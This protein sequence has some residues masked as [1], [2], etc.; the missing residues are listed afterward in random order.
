MYE[1]LDSKAKD[2]A[3][4][5]FKD[6]LW[7]QADL[8][9]QDSA[10][11]QFDS[12][13]I[14]WDATKTD[15]QDIEDS[16]SYYMLTESF[17]DSIPTIKLTRFDS[18]GFRVTIP[19]VVDLQDS[20]NVV[21]SE[22]PVIA[23]IEE[24]QAGE[25]NTKIMTP[26][27]VAEQIVLNA[28]PYYG[29]NEDIYTDYNISA[30]TLKSNISDAKNY[31][32]NY[33][34]NIV[35][36]S[37]DHTFADNSDSALVTER[38]IKAFV[39]N[40]ISGG[41]I[42]LGGW[43]ANTNTPT[44]SDATGSNGDMYSITVSGTQDLGSGSIVWTAGG[45]AIHNGTNYEF[46][47]YDA[48]VASV[49]EFTGTVTLYPELSG[50]TLRIRGED[51]YI[52]IGNATS[53][54]NNASNISDNA[55]D[56]LSNDNDIAELNDSITVHR[57]DINQNISNISDNT[58]SITAHRADIDINLG[59]DTTGIYHIN[60]ALLDAISE[61]DTTYWGTQ[62]NLILVDDTLYLSLSNDTISLKY[63][64]DSISVHRADINQNISDISDNA[65]SITLHRADIN[66]NIS[67]ISDLNDSIDVHRTLIDANTGKDT[68]G[69]Y[70]A[71][72]AL[73]DVITASDTARWGEIADLSGYATRTELSDT[74]DVVRSEIPLLLTELDSVG[75]R[76]TEGQIS[77]LQHFTNSD[78]TDH[79]YKADSASI[80]FETDII[81]EQDTGVSRLATILETQVGENN[82]LLIT[83][84]RNAEDLEINAVPYYGAKENIY[85]NH[86]ITG[87]SIFAN[88]FNID[89][90][91]IT[92]STS[93][94]IG[95]EYQVTNEVP[96]G[97]ING[98]N[99]TFTTDYNF[100]SNST[101][102]FLNGVKQILG[103]NY[104]EGSGQIIFNTGYIPYS[105]D[106]LTINYRR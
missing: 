59:K 56:I 35:D 3:D 10:Y 34:V 28:V 49:N 27:R 99:D 102:V 39:Q 92:I 70:H 16:L 87:D 22:I 42:Y 36:F 88:Y 48:I 91:G 62:Q 9:P 30:D 33:G 74:A 78:E 19:Q 20:L 75:F 21:K 45:F 6:I 55:A 12:D 11:I 80:I 5:L 104:T 67:G 85:T 98:S 23:T 7:K 68:I 54:S 51:T 53:V 90:E 1:P 86:N 8:Y 89:M 83:P 84:L 2:N 41:V 100:I 93:Q 43:N 32:A 69:I 47:G 63:F 77:D 64:T 73:L 82:E 31:I 57:T 25:D 66:T 14:I 58:D 26:L 46:V 94:V 18:T 60:R 13:T 17:T 29:A 15:V 44:L 52:K 106:L 38:A 79:L 4:K 101:E 65:D 95:Y 105:G 50:D 103:T 24:A 76:I 81:S 97:S 61:S 71:N 96:E 40:S 72:R 37:D